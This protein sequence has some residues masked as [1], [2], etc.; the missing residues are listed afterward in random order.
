MRAERKINEGIEMAASLYGG[1]IT[2]ERGNFGG[3]QH[4]YRIR[5]TGYFVPGVTSVLNILD[6]P[7]LIQWSA[8]LA[9]KYV[10]DNLPVNPTAEQVQGVCDRA[11]IE[12]KSVRDTAG[13]IG[14]DVHAFAEKIFR[15]IPAELPTHPKALK[16]IEALQKWIADSGVKPIDVELICFSKS[17]FFAG[18]MDLLA[19]VG[20]K[21]TYIDLK[22]GKGI[23]REHRLQCGAYK[24]A[25][26]EEHREP[27]QK[28]I[29]VNVNKETGKPKILEIEDR[30][31]MKFYENTFLR[32][33]ALAENLKKMD[34]YA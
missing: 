16:A 23:Y 19:D 28:I 18:T 27:I 13:D 14:K 1:Q 7:A 12:W 5:E 31:E 4:A 22:T 33:H 34:N 10:N 24:F 26:E 9:A 11:K 32:A 15:G 20:G 21:L 3:F 2:I 30:A 17:A 8:S 25:W 29:I 6:K